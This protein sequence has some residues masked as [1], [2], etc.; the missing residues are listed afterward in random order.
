LTVEF[1]RDVRRISSQIAVNMIMDPTLDSPFATSVLA[2]MREAFG[3]LWVKNVKNSDANTTN[4]LVTTWAFAGSTPWNAW[5][6]IYHDDRNTADRDH[7]NL[8]WRPEPE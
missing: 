4:M 1:F 5:G 6:V 7:V 2:S 3:P 8:L